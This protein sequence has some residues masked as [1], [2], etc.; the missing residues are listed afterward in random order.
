MKKILLLI[1]LLL[2]LNVQSMGYGIVNNSGSLGADSL[3]IPFFLV[4]SVG[5]P[6][7][8]LAS[9]DS[10]WLCVFYPSGV[11]AYD[12][13]YVYN[14]A[15][16]TEKA[17]HGKYFYSFKI[18]VAS[19]DGTARDGTY[20]YILNAMDR[21]SASLENAHRGTFQLYIEEDFDASLEDITD[22]EAMVQIL[23]DSIDAWDDNIAFLD[24][25]ITAG[26]EENDYVYLSLDNTTGDLD[27]TDYSGVSSLWNEG[28]TGYA[29]TTADWNVG[30]TGYS[31]TTADWNVGKTGYSLTT[32]DWTTTAD[33]PTVKEV[34]EEVWGV[35][36]DSAF[37][38]GSMGDSIADLL[39]A[40]MSS[41]GTSDLT[42]SDNIGINWGDVSNP[43]TA[44]GLS[45][46]TIGTVTTTTTATSVTNG[47]TL[48]ADAIT[49]AKIADSAFLGIN[50]DTDYWTEFMDSADA[51]NS[52]A[53][54]TWGYKIDTGWAAGSMGDSAKSWKG[55]AGSGATAADIVDT[56]L[57][58]KVDSSFFTN[59]GNDTTLMFAHYLLYPK[60][61]MNDSLMDGDSVF[62]VADSA[63]EVRT[64]IGDT[65]QRVATVAGDA[66]ALTTAERG[67]IEDSIHAQAADYKSVGDTIQRTAA[68]AGDAMTL[69][70][71][72]ITAAKID[73]NAIDSTKVNDNLAKENA[74]GVWAN[75]TRAL[76]SFD[77]DYTTID[78]DATTI[79]T[80]TN[81]TNDE[82]D[83]TDAV[84]GQIADT[85]WQND[86]ASMYA[87]GNGKVGDVFRDSAYGGVATISDANMGDIADSAY[88][89][90]THGSNEDVFK[91][92]SG[93][94][95]GNDLYVYAKKS[96]DS[97]VLS[98]V[99]ISINT[100]LDGSSG[101]DYKKLT[102]GNGLATFDMTSADDVYTSGLAAPPYVQTKSDSLTIAT[103][104]DTVILYFS[105]PII[106]G[107]ASPNMAT[108]WGQIEKNDSAVTNGKVYIEL[109]APDSAMI[110]SLFIEL[111]KYVW[112][113][114][115]GI[116]ETT[117]YVN[118]DMTD[119]AKCYYRM[120]EFI[121]DKLNRKLY[122]RVDDTATANI[123]TLIIGSPE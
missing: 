118:G 6:G 49:S 36:F 29:L 45:G 94:G 109:I 121:G 63:N 85:V 14:N 15:R 81:I 116:W 68:V 21:T 80:V 93:T 62:Q 111:H 51:A 1:A 42:T 82:M 2:A 110:D 40:A 89:V 35:A 104:P 107:S 78:I 95:G 37:A 103:D 26:Y 18:D 100:N 88:N 108:V 117:V 32:A 24:Q 115:L 113:D 122:F 31:L 39:D 112:T 74:T 47:V 75:A 71:G 114:T 72:A 106:T 101:S 86:T 27:A 52:F 57:K 73:A 54:Q 92:G 60:M 53:Q 30:K 64:A 65:I 99:W 56:M 79:G 70:D 87:G 11:V 46:T 23:D 8:Q 102:N 33:I 28:K 43:T 77:E 10:V 17:Y 90:F 20:A 69:S 58:R 34:T 61:F 83:L 5:N 48:A 12:S 7:L 105:A 120:E 38:D 76:T 59:P 41:R 16:I 67:H 44:V 98:G 19:V 119:S 3:C 13:G 55:I 4:D 50:F 25:A 123:K 9:G 66:M 22:I 96:S 84:I 91:G 97:T